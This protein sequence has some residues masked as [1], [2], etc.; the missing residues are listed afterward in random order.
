MNSMLCGTF[1]SI[2]AADQPPD[3]C[4]NILMAGITLQ[5]L[6]WMVAF[7][8]FAVYLHRLVEYGLPAPDL[9]PGMFISA[10]PPSFTSLALIGMARALPPEASFFQRH[11]TAIENMQV[12]A[13]FIGVFLW[14]LS[15]WFFCTASLAVLTSVKRMSFHLTWWAMVFPNVGFT[16]ATI[17]IGEEFESEGILWLGSVMTVLLVGMWMF[18]FVCHVRAVMQRQILMPG[19][20]EDRGES[21]IS[22]GC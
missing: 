4:M 3:H 22:K 15:F 6:G 18:V 17:R 7:L 13:A 10:G 16:I 20:D 1:A 2:I 11:T 12:L 19:K 14:T 21:V 5:G 9:R 8:M